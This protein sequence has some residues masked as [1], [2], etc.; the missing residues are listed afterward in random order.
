VGKS[1]GIVG[2]VLALLAAVWVLGEKL[3]WWHVPL[4]HHADRLAD[5]LAE[6]LDRV[7]VDKHIPDPR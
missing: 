3:G 2:A 6:R 5:S 4:A 1:V 7:A